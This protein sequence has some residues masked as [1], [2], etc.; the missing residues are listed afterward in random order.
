MGDIMVVE[1]IKIDNDDYFMDSLTGIHQE[2]YDE[3]TEMFDYNYNIADSMLVRVTEHF[4]F[5]GIIKTPLNANAQ[6]LEYPRNFSYSINE[7]VDNLNVSEE[8]KI[9]V[10]ESLKVLISVPRTTVHFCINGLVGGHA[11]GEFDDKP[12]VILEP[13]INHIDEVHTLRV[14]DTY[15][16]KNLELS[17]DAVL[18]IRKDIYEQI[19]DDPKYQEDLTRFKLYIFD[20]K[21]MQL[22]VGVVLNKLGYDSFSISSNGYVDGYRTNQPAGRMY[23]FINNYAE[24]NNIDQTRHF[25]SELSIETKLK[26]NDELI[27]ITKQIINIM[28]S[29]L[30]KSEHEIRELNSVIDAGF[31]INTALITNLINEYG[32]EKL[33]VLISNINQE[34]MNNIN[35]VD[36]INI[37]K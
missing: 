30:G 5:G 32:L 36:S 34:K 9:K 33:I 23:D 2:Y 12:Y 21:N 7:I 6:L 16:D 17:S 4:P 25:N 27:E 8:E 28:A 13:L 3:Y 35:K 31:N 10:K 29:S 24:A 18:I 22:A 11:F 15:F 20:G 26:M 19:K 14:E 1:E 37:N